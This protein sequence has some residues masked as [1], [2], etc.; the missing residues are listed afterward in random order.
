M[1]TVSVCMIV[2]NEEAVLKRCLDSLCNLV[3]EIIIVDTGST[4]RTKEIA[5]QYTDQIYDYAWSDDFAAARN[6]A[7][8]KAHMD[9]IYSADADEVLDE[10]NQN[11]FL[12]L[13]EAMLPEVE[14]VQMIYLTDMRY[15]TTE[16]YVR[17]IR[18]KL[19]KRLRSFTWIEPVH[20]MVNLDPV[21]YN[22]E[23][24]ILHM[25]VSKHQ[26]R[27]FSIFEKV[28]RNG[29]ELSD[30][31]LKM[32]VRELYLSGE[33]TDF[34]I[35]EPYLLKKYDAY[36][37]K[38]QLNADMPKML[39]AALCKGAYMNQK[40]R[41][42]TRMALLD[43]TTGSSAEVC[44]LLGEYYF[45]CK[46]YQDALQWY[47]CAAHSTESYLDIHSSGDDALLA[48][49]KVL[50]ITGDEAQAEAYRESAFAWRTEHGFA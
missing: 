4:D 3:E 13:K 45:S 5:K 18:P 35:A 32:Y 9:Y 1:I 33:A 19:Y 49:A 14:I 43:M 44:Y 17:D 6:F 20:E 50:E 39:A 38:Q 10:E 25:P 8:S 23:I 37:S 22:S 34:A 41:L 36:M 30:R 46:E 2:K 29:A 48:I 31:L 15:N 11:R 47:H 40:D 7:F 28:I 12:L 24:E 21:V 42:L 16:N 27:D 26:K